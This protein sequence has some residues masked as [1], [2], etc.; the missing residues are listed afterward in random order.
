MG[1]KDA[2]RF[3]RSVVALGVLWAFGVTLLRG[4][5]RPNDWAEAHWLISY[6][7]GLV[8]RGLP[9]TMLRP[10]V[11]VAPAQTEV[12]ITLISTALTTLLCAALLYQ[13]WTILSRSDFSTNAVAAVAVFV[14][15]PFV[16]MSGHLNGYFDGQIILLTILAVA[17]TWR[18]RPGW[19]ALTLTIGLLIHETIFII[20]YP[21]V[22]WTALLANARDGL[23][24][25]TAA[26]RL[27]PLI[28]PLAAFTL[29]IV[30]QSYAI[31]V[32]Q[33]ESTLTSH[34][35][36]FPFIQ[37]EQEIIVPR[38]FA[39]SFTGHF[40]SQSPRVWGRLF[41]L[42]LM[43]A[44]LPTV[45]VWLLFTRGALHAGSASRRLAIASA[46]LP[47]LPLGLHL[48]AWDTARI[49]TY[50]IMV[51]FLV[52]WVACLAA[53]PERLRATD[54]RLLTAVAL[55]TLPLNVFGRMP[56]M[57]ER[58]E[59]FTAAWRALLYGLPAVALMMALARGRRADYTT[60]DRQLTAERQ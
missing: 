55:L 6:D 54:S 43:A 27:V 12:I 48:I 24:G 41:D 17:L 7:F 18:G 47:F 15:S 2:H 9:A 28:W 40:R 50:P 5:R 4:L 60:D 58:V 45:L 19:A 33:L 59:R 36:T 32:A 29:L 44:M 53:E 34:L 46:L 52:G 10:F 13:C 25:R 8:K 16:V 30:Y 11:G 42:R 14:T 49:W 31:D 20:G 57:D 26:R 38:A 1:M 37:R 56:L 51:A 3:W 23:S 35:K 22:V 39:K 21:T